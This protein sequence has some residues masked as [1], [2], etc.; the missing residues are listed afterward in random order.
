MSQVSNLGHH[1][2]T[3]RFPHGVGISRKFMVCTSY[4]IKIFERIPTRLKIENL[5]K[6]IMGP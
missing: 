6:Y 5:K 4:L 3:K 1:Q 2:G